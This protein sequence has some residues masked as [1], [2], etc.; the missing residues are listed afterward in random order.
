MHKKVEI[1]ATVPA[2]H[3]SAAAEA[4]AARREVDKIHD[5]SYDSFPASDPPSWTGTRA[6]PAAPNR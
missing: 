3:V 5:A 4:T 6:G 1:V 2:Q